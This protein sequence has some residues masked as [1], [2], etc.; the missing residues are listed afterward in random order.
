MIKNPK[1]NSLYLSGSIEYNSDPDTWR[2]KMKNELKHKYHVI[3][4]WAA[5]PPAKK[6][7]FEYNNWILVNFVMPDLSDV[8]RS[9]FFFVRVDNGVLKVAGTI[10]EVSLATWFNRH[11]VAFLD[12]VTM[13]DLPGWM[14]GCLTNA[15]FVNSVDNAIDF[16]KQLNIEHEE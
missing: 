13:K 8:A 4:P 5:T 9:R 15:T 12:D 1:R 7:D 6:G 14:C 3:V 10:S 16:Y 11:I 2:E